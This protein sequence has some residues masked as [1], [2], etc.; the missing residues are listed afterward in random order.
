MSISPDGR[1][2][3]S[4]SDYASTPRLQ[5]LP[6][7]TGQSRTIATRGLAVESASWFPDGK[8]ILLTASEPQRGVRLYIL[9]SSE[10]QP[11]AL[12]P[13]G[14]RAPPRSI[15]PDG[16]LATVIGPDQKRYLYPLSGGEPS[17]IPGLEDAE[18]AMGWT[19][20][21]KSLYVGRRGE[22]PSRIFLLDLATGKRQLWKELSPPDASGIS[23]VAPPAIAGDGQT[24]A[25]SYNR[26]LSDLFLADGLK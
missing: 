5:T 21:G 25:Y 17:P 10:A 16:R 3:L 23:N 11:R 2:A 4:V 13:L 20:D 7:G 26:I 1:W 14:Y 24:Y 12:S 8:R 6:T 15:S 18:S 9:D 22:Y 19:R